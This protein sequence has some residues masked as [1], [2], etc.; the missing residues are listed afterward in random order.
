MGD[1][2]HGQSPSFWRGVVRTY[3]VILEMMAWIAGLMA[4]IMM[5]AIVYSV[6]T[7]FFFNKPQPAVIELSGYML[8][9]TAFL[10]APWLLRQDGHVR[11]DLLVDALKPRARA[12][13]LG[14]TSIIGTLVS[15]VVLVWGSMITVDMFRR[16]VTVTNILET[17]QW[18]LMA[19]IPIGGF[20]LTIEFILKAI[21]LFSGSR[22]LSEVAPSLRE[23]SPDDLFDE[24]I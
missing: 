9:Y 24:G 7:R 13:L 4:V 14:V 12:V 1:K 22:P 17:P 15:L 5:L 8:L 19:V 20:F 21:Q 16:G 3:N 11:V 6:I 23:E 18:I 10:G 2:Y